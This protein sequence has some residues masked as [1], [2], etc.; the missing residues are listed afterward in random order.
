M[1]PPIRRARSLDKRAFTTAAASDLG[2][3]WSVFCVRSSAPSQLRVVERGAW[4]ARLAGLQPERARQ[5]DSGRVFGA[6]GAGRPRVVSAELGRAAAGRV[7]RV[8]AAHGAPAARAGR[9]SPT[10]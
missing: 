5:D 4:R 1:A 3:A 8:Y 2:R 6:G 7:G 10:R 9:G